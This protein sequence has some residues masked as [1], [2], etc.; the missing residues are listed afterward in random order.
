MRLMERMPAGVLHT[1]LAACNGYADG[2]AAARAVRCPV[3]LLQGARDLMAPPAATQALARALSDVRSVTLPDCGHALMAE[4]PD[5][6][7]DALRDFLR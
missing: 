1:D 2:L 7:L 4:Q 5:A 3:L 6:V